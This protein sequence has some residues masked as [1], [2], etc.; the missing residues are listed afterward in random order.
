MNRNFAVAKVALPLPIDKLFDYSIPKDLINKIQQGMRVNVLF[1]NKHN[2]GFVV[3]F[4]SK[5]KIKKLNPVINTL[6]K[7]PVVTA[8][9]LQLAHSI[10]DYYV[11]SL[12]EAI[13]SMLPEAVK[14]SRNINAD[15]SLIKCQNDKN[16]K[17]KLIYIR[18]IENDKTYA[19]FK[20]EIINVMKDKKRIIFVVPEIK[21]I[22]KAKNCFTDIPGIRI[23]IWHGKVPKKDMLKLW[24][25]LAKDEIDLIIGTR[26]CIFA[27]VKNLDLIIIDD[28]SNYAYKEDQV[29]YYH[30][31]RIAQMRYEIEGCGVI[32]SSVMPSS[33]IYQLIQSKKVLLK[34]TDSN[35]ILPEI[36]LTGIN[37][38]D[39]MD[40]MVEKE[41][42]SALQSKEK[43][44]I[45]LNK[46]G[47]ATFVYCK[48]CKE[49]IMC[50]RC[51]RNL[52]LDY[53]EKKL[54][55]PYCNFKTELVEICPKCNSGY[56][57]YGGFGI[58]K[59]ESN[60][61]RFFPQAKIII[62][63][64]LPK[65]NNDIRDCDIVIATTK[66]LNFPGY[67]PDI[68]IIWSLD[69]L[70]NV[71]D[72]NS[73]EETFQ[74]LS[75]LLIMTF[76]KMLISSSLNQDFY[77]LKALKNLDPEIFYKTELNTRKD[78]KL[79]PY[80][81]LGLVSLRSFD[82]KSVQASYSKLYSFLKG[83][84]TKGVE[85][86]NFDITQRSRLREK[87]YKY[88]LV[89]SSKIESLSRVFKKSMSKFRS[90]NVIIT[91]N[92]DPA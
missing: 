55:C 69:N 8:N 12:G 60:L 82:K 83:M 63:D 66:I 46:K 85:V 90:G 68:T 44:L 9:N 45:I 51:S 27:P 5:S 81:K 19:Y 10:K 40:L 53:S 73:G 72:F 62:L 28:E 80:Y 24:S 77:L 50:S 13:E 88:L 41:I 91:V 7:F 59:L 65:T 52:R 86:S 54:I 36:Q 4:S 23:A 16:K 58:E 75:K 71:G 14:K 29:P 15:F 39:K 43:I 38:K 64:A 26:S 34:E 92:V 18:N 78:L 89:K 61:K 49:T 21:M 84:N 31:S 67:K 48:N 17:S 6:D 11:C 87:Y 1:N 74:L 37:Y 2:I 25:D 76:R 57:K 22:D 33:Q 20:N 42:D 35:K 32:Y 70:L 3:G 47:F 30:T 56:V 79:P